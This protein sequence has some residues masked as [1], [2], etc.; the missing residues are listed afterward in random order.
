MAGPHSPTS[1]MSPRTPRASG[2]SV[3]SD[4]SMG[5]RGCGFRL[6]RDASPIATIPALQSAKAD[7]A[8]FQRRIPFARGPRAWNLARWDRSIERPIRE[9]WDARSARPGLCVTSTGSP[10]CD[11][12]N[13]GGRSGW[14]AQRSLRAL[15]FCLH[16]GQSI[17]REGRL[18]RRSRGTGTRPAPVQPGPGPWRATPRTATIPDSL[19]PSRPETPAA[20]AAAASG[21]SRPARGGGRRARVRRIRQA[22]VSPGRGSHRAPAMT[23]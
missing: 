9:T 4:G 20:P 2:G 19:S 12:R 1:P 13:V 18:P 17:S 21:A 22:R 6:C 23:V 14:R 8:W 16:L 7:F 11:R 10:V 5:D 3:R 15:A